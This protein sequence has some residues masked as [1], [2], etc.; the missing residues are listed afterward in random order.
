MTL[1]LQEHNTVVLPHRASRMQDVSRLIK[2]RIVKRFEFT[3]QTMMSGALAVPED[4]P[5]DTALLLV[6]GAPSVI[7]H[8]ARPGSVPENF[9]AVG[10]LAIYYS[11]LCHAMPAA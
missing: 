4:A 10:R 11:V 3:S 5:A 8:M 7:R 6:K 2:V 9:D 1:H